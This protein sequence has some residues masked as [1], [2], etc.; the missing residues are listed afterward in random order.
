V[1]RASELTQVLPNYAIWQMYEPAVKAELFSTAVRTPAGVV[2]VDPIPLAPD[3]MA[4]SGNIV[5][6]LI[7]NANHARAAADFTDSILVP[8]ELIRD[9]PNARQL[10]DGMCLHG[11]TAIA[12]PGAARGEFAFHDPRD[13]GTL[14]VGDALI[15]FEPHGFGLLP[16]KYCTNHKQLIR[17]LRRFLELQFNRMFFAHGYPLITGAHNQLATLLDECS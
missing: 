1:K 8:P 7:T 2:I 4:A 5:A 17:S 15:N 3:A 14:I 10:A 13:S 12:I 11:L 6:A 16:A 9:F